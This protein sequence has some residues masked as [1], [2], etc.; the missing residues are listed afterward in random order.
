MVFSKSIKKKMIGLFIVIIFFAS[1]IAFIAFQSFDTTI[2]EPTNTKLP[3]N[4]VIDG[5]L[6][7][8]VSYEFYRRGYTIIEFHYFENCCPDVL[9]T[10][11]TLPQQLEFDGG[12]QIIIQKI[13]ENISLS[14]PWVFA[15]SI[16]G[17]VTYNITNISII[18][19]PL[20]NILAKPP[21]ECGLLIQ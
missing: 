7:E 9:S 19:P 5:N 20:C 18:I 4:M 11:D 21:M 13:K 1:S 12:Y 17:N 8:A 6:D 10:M 3:D 15:D 16:Y 2:Q 14:Y